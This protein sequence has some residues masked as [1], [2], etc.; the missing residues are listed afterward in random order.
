[1]IKHAENLYTIYSHLLSAEESEKGIVSAGDK[2]KAGQCIGLAG[3]SGNMK[4]YGLGYSFCTELPKFFKNKNWDVPD[5]TNKPWS[6]VVQL[7]EKEG[8]P[9]TTTF[10]IDDTIPRDCVIATDPPAHSMVNKESTLIIIVS[11]GSHF[12]HVSDDENS[13]LDLSSDLDGDGVPDA[14]EALNPDMTSEDWEQWKV[15]EG[16]DK[17]REQEQQGNS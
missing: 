4:V 13:E 8:V 17:Q 15:F 10:R 3:M 16:I 9:H 7:L 2:V 11:M 6:E 12:D 5:F 14:L 1:M